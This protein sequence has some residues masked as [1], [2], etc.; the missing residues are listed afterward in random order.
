MTSGQYEGPHPFEIELKTLV[1]EQLLEFFDTAFNGVWIWDMQDDGDAWVTNAF[2]ETFGYSVSEVPQGTRFW[3]AICHPDDWHKAVDEAVAAHKNHTPYDVTVRFR[4][5]RG[6]WVWTRA[7]GQV[8]CGEGDCRMFGVAIDV[9][10]I[11]KM[12]QKLE[13]QN[14]R[15]P[16]TN[17]LNRR[18]LETAIQ[19]AIAHSDR[20]EG[21]TKTYAA[22][23]DLDNF[24]EVNSQHG[25]AVGDEVLEQTALRMRGALRITDEC[26]RVG[27]DEFIAIVTCRNRREAEI[28]LGRL[29]AG[30]SRSF[31][32]QDHTV[33]ISCS[34][35]LVRLSR[36]P[37]RKCATLEEVIKAAAPLLLEGKSLGK[38]R[39][40]SPESIVPKGVASR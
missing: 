18:G 2:I 16:L 5:K 14:V 32:F 33:D 21:A 35:A 36:E 7:K 20:S 19:K 37:E 39:L 22:F 38:N 31:E 29:R 8:R 1:S 40:I 26:G 24:K 28:V 23:I 4:H 15:D 9:T 11:M 12:A 3:K 13:E 25:H 30:V 34:A 17:L 6:H 10:E 27:G